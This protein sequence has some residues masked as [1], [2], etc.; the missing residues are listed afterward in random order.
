MLPCAVFEKTVKKLLA[1]RTEL[2]RHLSGTL[3]A[4]RAREDS[5]QG[6]YLIAVR[7]FETFL[8]EEIILLASGKA[9][10]ASRV[11]NGTRLRHENR[12]RET[13]TRMIKEVLLAGKNY[14]DYLPY[15]RCELAARLVFVGGR[16]FT[17]LGDAE[18]RA[19]TRCLSVRNY[20]AHESEFSRKKYLKSYRALKPTLIKTPRPAQYLDDNIRLGVT[21]FENDLIQMYSIS[22]FLS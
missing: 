10:W 7:S 17:Y 19:L 12:L 18:R 9:H 16:P 2:N 1:S 5:L 13:R 20:I 22:R 4:R 6:L 11:V 21:M 14:T 3:A 8:E 15:E